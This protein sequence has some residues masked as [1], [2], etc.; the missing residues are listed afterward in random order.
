[1]SKFLC[2]DDWQNFKGMG[3]RLRLWKG[4]MVYEEFITA[5]IHSVPNH[6]FQDLHGPMFLYHANVSNKIYG[7][8]SRAAPPSP[9][10][11][12]HAALRGVLQNY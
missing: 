2:N 11:N 6:D 9:R 5:L 3:S 12:L 4:S 8:S 7:I 1:M 10:I